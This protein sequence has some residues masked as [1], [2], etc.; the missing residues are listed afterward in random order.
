MGSSA[1]N[2]FLR[3]SLNRGARV[4]F[5]NS[6]AAAATFDIAAPACQYRTMKVFDEA[7]FR[8]ALPFDVLPTDVSGVFDVPVPP[9]G[10]DPRTATAEELRRAGMRWRRSVANRNPP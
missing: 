1:Q 4:T 8:R 3:L 7:E 9:P 2:S 5:A 6:S 10:F